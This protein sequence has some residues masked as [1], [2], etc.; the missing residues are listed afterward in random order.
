MNDEQR[1][2]ATEAVRLVESSAME[3]ILCFS[4]MSDDV[5]AIEWTQL[6]ADFNALSRIME[7]SE[8]E[9]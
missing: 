2:R 6:Q 4:C 1:E 9:L 7:Q 3:L 5:I 8:G